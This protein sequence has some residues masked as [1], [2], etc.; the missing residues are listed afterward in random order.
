MTVTKHY[1]NNHVMLYVEEGDL[2]EC[3]TLNNDHQI[4]RLGQCLIDLDRTEGRTAKIEERK[5]SR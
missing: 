4:R 5:V 1:E 3:I 2:K